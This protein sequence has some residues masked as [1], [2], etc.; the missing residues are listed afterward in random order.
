MF[1]SYDITHI[2]RALTTLPPNVH[3][4]DNCPS[5]RQYAKMQRQRQAKNSYAL[6]P[7]QIQRLFIDSAVTSTKNTLAAA[8][9]KGDQFKMPA[10]HVA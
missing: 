10:S 9:T 4:A 7:V 1:K 6:R 5:M 8:Y 2:S 3:H